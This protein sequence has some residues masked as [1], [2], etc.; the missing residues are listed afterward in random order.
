MFAGRFVPHTKHIK[1]KILDKHVENTL[2][3]AT[4]YIKADI[5]ELP[6]KQVFSV[7][8]LKIFIPFSLI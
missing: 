6:K 1:N 3:I 4:I 5:D 8:S 7:F 2:R